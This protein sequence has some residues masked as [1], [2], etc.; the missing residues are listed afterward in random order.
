MKVLVLL[1]TLYD[2]NIEKALPGVI[3]KIL[4]SWLR[5][6]ASRLPSVELAALRVRSIVVVELTRLGDLV[7][8]LPA[9]ISLR[10]HFPDAQIHVM[11]DASYA[12]LLE[13]CDADVRLMPVAGSRRPFAFLSALLA[14]RRLAPDVVCSMS[15]ANRNAALALASGAP[16]IVG[17]LNWANSLTPSLGISPVESIGV[18]D[19]A[20]VLFGGENI[21]TRPDKVLQSLGIRSSRGAAFELSG[22]VPSEAVTR[23]LRDEGVTGQTPYV[24]IHPFSRWTYRSWPPERFAALVR[25]ALET[26]PHD[27]IFLCHAS[28]NALLRPLR[29]RC[30]EGERVRFFVSSDIYRTAAVMKGAAAFVGNDSGLIHLAAVL[31]LPL[32]GLYGPAAPAQSAPLSSDGAFLYKPVVCS[33]CD[34]VRCLMPDHPCMT[35]IE[36]GEVFHALCRQLGVMDE[37]VANG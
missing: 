17:Y 24:V 37:G 3:L 19:G 11:A 1:R 8:V 16:F 18:R 5:W 35:L 9:V 20:R 34:Q 26:L 29:A 25:L 22:W 14:V 23:S 10:R 32:V 7:T 2:T 33:P 12:P 30:P 28:E 21:E 36:P 27:V 6:R 4:V 31:G 13:L 15:P